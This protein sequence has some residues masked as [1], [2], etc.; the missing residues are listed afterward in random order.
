MRSNRLIEQETNLEGQRSDVSSQT[1][2]SGFETK[3]LYIKALLAVIVLT[4]FGALLI[5]IFYVEVPSS[6]ETLCATMLGGLISTVHAVTSH[7]FDSTDQAER[8]SNKRVA[9]EKKPSK[10]RKRKNV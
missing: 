8:D 3:R 6:M 10:N 9:E 7:F 5:L 1:E 4:I 2:G